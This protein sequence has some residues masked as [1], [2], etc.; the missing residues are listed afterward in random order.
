MDQFPLL[1]LMW[2]WILF[3]L[4][5]KAP[6]IQCE[7]TFRKHYVTYC[8][9]SFVWSGVSE[10]DSMICDCDYWWMSLVINSTQHDAGRKW[11][12]TRA[13]THTHTRVRTKTKK[14]LYDAGLFCHQTRVMS[15]EQEAQLINSE[16]GIPVCTVWSSPSNGVQGITGL[17]WQRRAVILR[18]RP[19]KKV[20]ILK[21]LTLNQPALLKPRH[22]CVLTVSAAFRASRHSLCAAERSHRFLSFTL[23]L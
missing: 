14:P 21:H 9:L 18:E 11:E 13:C 20:V 1:C 8:D 16:V 17:T 5:W 2:I 15:A 22:V 19:D 7:N 12:G 23:Y 3:F 10:E 4:W 6:E